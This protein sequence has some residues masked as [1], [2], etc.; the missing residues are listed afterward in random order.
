[1]FYWAHQA[2][3]CLGKKKSTG[4]IGRSTVISIWHDVESV[5]NH[6]FLQILL[7]DYFQVSNANKSRE[8]ITAIYYQTQELNK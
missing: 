4:V 7:L 3:I 5:S 6:V 1:M 2:L 8:N